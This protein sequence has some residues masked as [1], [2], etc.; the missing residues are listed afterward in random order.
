MHTDM[1]T[2]VPTDMCIGMHADMHTDKLTAKHTGMHMDMHKEM[3]SHCGRVLCA[4]KPPPPS[5]L[6][7]PPPPFKHHSCG[8]CYAPHCPSRCWLLSVYSAL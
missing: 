1:H 5:S 6:Y 3:F 8:S 7:A 2:G 4:A